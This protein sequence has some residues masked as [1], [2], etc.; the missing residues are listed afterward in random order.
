MRFLFL[1]VIRLLR[2]LQI[3]FKCG[4]EPNERLEGL[5]ESFDG[6]D[7]LAIHVGFAPIQIVA[8]AALDVSKQKDLLGETLYMSIM[9][10]IANVCETLVKNG[11]RLSLEEPPAVRCTLRS[12]SS[13]VDCSNGSEEGNDDVQAVD[14]S[15]L[16]IH[17]NKPLA[18]LL[19]AY[20]LNSAE[21]VWG[22]NKSAKSTGS[23][24]FHTDKLA[25]E[26]SEAPGGSDE[27]SCA[28]CWKKF[29]KLMN[30]KHRCRISRRHA[31]DE[32]SSKR[33]IGKDGEEH[34]VSDGQFLL[35]RS[36]EA[37]EESKQLEAAKREGIAKQS[38]NS[39]A[40]RLDRLEADERA[41][42]DSLFGGVMESMSKAVFGGDAEET[43]ES[44]ASNIEGLSSQLNQTR[45]ALNE[46]GDK[47]NT[48]A[49]KSD[50]LVNASKDFEAMARELNKNSNQGFFW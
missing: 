16:K 4:F 37:D 34:R 11:A 40:A 18:D 5:L 29:G 31:C 25:I 43:E 14:R 36:D 44:H 32:C 22:A 7:E 39:T 13:I 15:D 21:M 12:S 8:A 30:R 1:I 23:F 48:L 20:R 50:K 45:D 33:V 10:F 9:G 42:R 28:I 41:N 3:L 38:Q 6:F 46:R 2:T 24:I 17:S 26:D 19:G 47:L 35:A 27:K 49:E